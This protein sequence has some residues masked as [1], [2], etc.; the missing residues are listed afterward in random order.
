MLQCLSGP[1]QMLLT[2]HTPSHTEASTCPSKPT[3]LLPLQ[4]SVHAQGTAVSRLVCVATLQKASPGAH[5]QTEGCS[6]V[7]WQKA[8][9]TRH[10]HVL[11]E[12]RWGMGCQQCLQGPGMSEAPER[13]ALC[14]AVQVLTRVCTG[15]PSTLQQQ[16]LTA[17][18]WC[19]KPLSRPAALSCI[20][21]ETT[22][23]HS[24]DDC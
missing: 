5:K 10:K 2:Q 22:V 8:A 12:C 24:S 11:Q 14:C 19:S 18:C 17:T 1:V 6:S 21:N 7:G 4:L 9:N 20:D 15:V 13:P 16:P 23:P 3:S